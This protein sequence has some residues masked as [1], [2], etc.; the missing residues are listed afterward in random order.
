MKQKEGRD[1]LEL[2]ESV[3]CIDGNKFCIADT[4]ASIYLTAEDI[5]LIVK[6]ITKLKEK[7]HD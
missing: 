2:S 7:K 1:W 5:K 3:F 4:G 6:F